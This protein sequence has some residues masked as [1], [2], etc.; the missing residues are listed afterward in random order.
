MVI[1]SKVLKN[2]MYAAPSMPDLGQGAE[3]Y[4]T[5]AMIQ[6]YAKKAQNG[7]AI[8]TVTGFLPKSDVEDETLRFPH[9]DMHDLGTQNYLSQLTEAI[10]MYG[11]LASAMPGCGT[12][13]GYDVV[14]GI[15]SLSVEG[16]NSQARIGR[17]IT[18]ELMN[19]MADDFAEQAYIF[20]DCGF[21]MVFLHTAYRM[22][23]PSRFLSPITNK[24]TDEYGGNIANRA[25]FLFMFCDRIKQRCGKDF[26][27]G[28]SIGAFEPKG[29][30]TLEEIIE[31]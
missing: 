3:N 10:H 26:L 8:V 13:A 19:K 1:G 25:K 15:E 6:Q 22:H 2:R 7:A 17:E 5:T 27:I 18:P 14:G 30:N 31:F 28:A 11:S 23:L 24:R 12:M 29:G 21:D 4:P 20:K 9:F 16:D